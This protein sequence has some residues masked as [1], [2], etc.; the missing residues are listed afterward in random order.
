MGEQGDPKLTSSHGYT[1][2]TTNYGTTIDEKD[3]KTIRKNLLQQ[4]L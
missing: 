2:I 4:K 3:W 1:K